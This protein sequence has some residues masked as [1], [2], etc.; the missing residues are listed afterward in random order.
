MQTKKPE[1]EKRRRNAMRSCALVLVALWLATTWALPGAG[2]L[3]KAQAA[4]PSLP[5]TDAPD[6]NGNSSAIAFTDISGHWAA[7]VIAQA[8]S[9]GLVDGYAD[10]TF[11]PSKAVTRAEFTTILVRALAPV[12]EDPDIPPVASPFADQASIRD[13]AGASIAQA[14]LL[15]WAQGD[16]SGSFRPNDAVTRAEMANMLYRA[17][18]LKGSDEAVLNR[19]ADADSIPA[20]AREAAAAL[21]ATGVLQGGSGGTFAPN[22][23]ATRAEIVQVLMRTYQ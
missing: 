5:N 21:T 18:T 7:D 11:R 3:S 4:V 8:A 16:P 6:N 15:G 23:S 12:S 17:L 19:F 1:T 13:W 22:A 20:W 10:G 9:L 2:G 14:R